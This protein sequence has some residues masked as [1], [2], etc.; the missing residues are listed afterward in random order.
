[1]VVTNFFLYRTVLPVIT[2]PFSK[3]RQYKW[4]MVTWEGVHK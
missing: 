2:I 1:M 4:L 3:E